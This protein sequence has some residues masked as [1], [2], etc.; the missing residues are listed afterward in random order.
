MSEIWKDIEG[1]EGL[2]QVSNTGMVKSLGKKVIY[3]KSHRTLK[4]KMLKPSEYPYCR[5]ALSKEG[6]I[7]QYSVHRLVAKAFITNHENKRQINHKNCVKTDNRVE[8]LEWATVR[9]NTTHAYENIMI[10]G[11]QKIVL[12]INN[13]VYYYSARDAARTYG[14]SSSY[15]INMLNN[16]INNKTSLRYV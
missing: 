3:K 5:V 10:E 11:I 13:G 6:V 2:Y 12:D 1:Y 4:E 7:N 8:N 14:V 9:E 16:K 15:M